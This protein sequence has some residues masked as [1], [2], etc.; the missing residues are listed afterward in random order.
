[1][2]LL[3]APAISSLIANTIGGIAGLGL[4]VNN[5]SAFTLTINTPIKIE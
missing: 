5:S 3:V 1:M 4:L 2:W